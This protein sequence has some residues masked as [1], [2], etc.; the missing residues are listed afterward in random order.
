MVLGAVL[1]LVGGAVLYFAM[2]GRSPRQ[3][4]ADLRRR[5]DGLAAPTDDRAQP[6]FESGPGR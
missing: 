5:G 6:R 3:A 1:V 4:L 2:T